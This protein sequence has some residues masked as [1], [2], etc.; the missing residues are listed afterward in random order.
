MRGGHSNSKTM[1]IFASDLCTTPE[2]LFSG[3]PRMM[4]NLPIVDA[5]S[6]AASLLLHGPSDSVVSD[7]RLKERKLSKWR[8]RFNGIR[9][10][11]LGAEQV[12]SAPTV[13]SKGKGQLDVFVVGL[14]SQVWTKW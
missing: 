6:F 2:R 5:Y 4:Q 7:A 1:G 11:R 9:P 12:L 13:A 14:D 8:S 10:D 3:P